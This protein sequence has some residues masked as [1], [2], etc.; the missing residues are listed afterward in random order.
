MAPGL[1]KELFPLWAVLTV[2]FVIYQLFIGGRTFTLFMPID[3][4][5]AWQ[6]IRLPLL[7]LS[8]S[9][10]LFFYTTGVCLFPRVAIWLSAVVFSGYFLYGAANSARVDL[11]LGFGEPLVYFL[12]P[13]LPTGL[14]K[15][16]SWIWGTFQFPTLQLYAF[17]Y[18]LTLYIFFTAILTFFYYPARERSPKHR[19]S[20]VDV[21]LFVIT[22][23]IVLNYIVNFADR[24]ERAGIIVWHDVIMG[25]LAAA[26]SIEMCRRLLGWVLPALGILF[27]VYAVHGNAISGRLHHAGFTWNELSYFLFGSEGIF[28]V[29]A[30]VYASYVFLFIIFGVFLEMTKVGDVFVKLSFALVGHLRGGPAKAAVVSSGLVG[31]I[32]GSGAPNIVITGTFTIPMMKRSGFMPHFAAAVEAVASTGGIL[33]PPVMGSAAFLMA[34]FT[35]IDYNYIALVA[36]MPA[37]MY[38]YQCYMS[39]HHRAGLWGI[40]GIPKEELPRLGEVMRKEGYLLLPVLVLVIRLVIGRSPFDAALWAIMLSI[41]LGFFRE[42]TRIIGL[43]PLVA[44][45]LGVPP[46]GTGVDWARVRAEE[47]KAAMLRDHHSAEKI[48]AEYQRIVAEAVAAPRG[49]FWR[50]NWMLAAGTAVPAVLLLAGAEAGQSLFWGVTAILVLSSPRVLD[51]LEKGALNSL[52]IGVTAGVV[53]V[54]LAGISLPGLGLKFPS[55]V[56]GYAQTFVDLFGWQW[57]ELPMVILL[58]GA[59]AYVMG[60][61]MT[62]SAAYILLSVLAVPALLKLGVPLLNAHLL[63][64]WFTVTAPLT[65][66]F[67]L[68]AFIAA[69][70]AG[71]DPM[72]TGF[73]SVRLAWALYIVPFLMAYTPILMNKDASWPH[74]LVVWVTTFMGFYCTAA[75]FEGFLRCRLK[76]LERANFLLAAFLLFSDVWWTF[77]L[78]TLLMIAGIVVQNVRARGQAEAGGPLPIPAESSSAPASP[79]A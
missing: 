70:I 68:G 60:M 74:I 28:G 49:T 41:F 37:V 20:V 45:A 65:P 34:A 71:A 30:G 17:Q 52:I 10:V 19:P 47:V 8:V 14:S 50:E 31:M 13:V 69:G 53:G 12:G 42:D 58:C 25:F 54:M 16:L 11:L 2:L 40:H 4:E 24:G 64:L 9:G 48:E 44:R 62:A 67:A 26:I 55:I 77:S 79:P 5:W 56:L 15:N 7:S 51:G 22:L 1:Q 66:P 75:G 72:R 21:L 32:C 73:A 39:V 27:C 6:E 35:E 57:T 29:V 43:P 3:Y 38:Y 33:M 61:G 23:G 63:T 59:A 18:Y 78:G 76:V 46:W 36:F